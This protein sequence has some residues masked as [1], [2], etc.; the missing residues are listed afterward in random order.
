MQECI[1]VLTLARIIFCCSIKQKKNMPARWRKARYAEK[2]LKETLRVHLLKEDRIK[3]L[4]QARINRC[5]TDNSG[6]L[7]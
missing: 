5:M 2:V 3:L 1:E 7:L 6:I 4:C